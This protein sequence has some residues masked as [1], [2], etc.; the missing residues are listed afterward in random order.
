M[1]IKVKLSILMIAIMMAVV[2]GL[3]VLLLR[4]A[5]GIGKDLSLQGVHYLAGQRAEYWKAQED[6]YIQI[7]HTLSNVMSYYEGIPA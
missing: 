4:Q 5:S 3:S 6:R 2:T 7:L 1:K